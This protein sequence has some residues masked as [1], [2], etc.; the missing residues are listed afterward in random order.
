[1]GSHIAYQRHV[2]CALWR[3]DTVVPL[4]TVPKTNDS[5]KLNSNVGDTLLFQFRFLIVTQLVTAATV[6]FSAPP[7]MA[8]VPQRFESSMSITFHVSPRGGLMID[9]I[10]IGWTRSGQRL[11]LS[12]SVVFSLAFVTGKR[13]LEDKP[14][15]LS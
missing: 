5:A 8:A 10:A 9:R 13:P 1:M 3:L 2:K 11:R 15:T 4:A 12:P 14:D 6:G 7:T